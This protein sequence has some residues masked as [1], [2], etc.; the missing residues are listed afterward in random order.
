V[1]YDEGVKFACRPDCGRCCTRHGDYDYV[2]LER[3][4]VARLAGHL[5]VTTAAFR[6]QWTRKEEGHTVLR[7]DGPAC[8]F[9]EGTRCSVY[10]ARPSQCET[11]PFWGENLADRA[12]WEGLQEFC[13]GV[14]AGEIIPLHVIRDQ[15]R[16]HG[17]S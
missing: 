13:P 4:D 7:M 14:G 2:Y 5:G 8:P 12:T 16:R 15:L 1:W 9:L 6:A 17:S 3:K 10:A 11:F